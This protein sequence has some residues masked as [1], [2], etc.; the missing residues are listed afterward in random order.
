MERDDW[1]F[2]W[3]GGW[4]GI[5]RAGRVEVAYPDGMRHGRGAIP[6]AGSFPMR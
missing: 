6:K 1:Q 3:S 4:P 5:D 2:P